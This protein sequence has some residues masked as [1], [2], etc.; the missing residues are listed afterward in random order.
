MIKHEKGKTT[1][2]YVDV[3]DLIADW[4]EMT[5]F[6][7][8]SCIFPKCDVDKEMFKSLFGHVLDVSEEIYEKEKENVK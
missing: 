7:L 2:D 5:I 1:F 3:D 4:M 8:S 6:M